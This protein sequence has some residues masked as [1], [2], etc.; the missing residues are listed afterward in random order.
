MTEPQTWR[1]EM[2]IEGR[3]VVVVI[4]TVKGVKRRCFFSAYGP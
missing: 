2:T 1:E 4:I 3:T